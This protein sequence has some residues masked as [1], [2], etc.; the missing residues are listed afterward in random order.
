MGLSGSFLCAVKKH[1]QHSTRLSPLQHRTSVL[2]A[3]ARKHDRWINW[4]ALVDIPYDTLD[5]YH[6]VGM[7]F[8]QQL[9]MRVWQS[10]HLTAVTATERLMLDHATP[11]GLTLSIIILVCLFLWLSRFRAFKWF[12]FPSDLTLCGGAP[13]AGLVMLHITQ[14]HRRC[15][16]KIGHP[17][18][19]DQR[20]Q[21]AN[22]VAWLIHLSH[23]ILT[24]LVRN[25]TQHKKSPS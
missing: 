22:I 11:I 15:T 20:K 10:S 23:T 2:A 7:Y 19:A 1:R 5:G 14:V 24:L 3:E 16:L 25:A 13:C 6:E 9:H 4:F 18:C 8:S 17:D 12:R 21:A